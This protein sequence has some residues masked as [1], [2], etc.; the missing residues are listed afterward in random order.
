LIEDLCVV[1]AVSWDTWRWRRIHPA[2]AIGAPALMGILHVAFELFRTPV[3][4]RFA[5]R[6]FG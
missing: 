2:F 5:M 6:L 4:T 3:W 1:G